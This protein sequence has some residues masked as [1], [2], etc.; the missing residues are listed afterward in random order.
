MVIHVASA[1]AYLE[2]KNF[3]HRDL[4]R[5]LYMWSIQLNAIVVAW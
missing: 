4:V 2:S 5:V 1:M 3:I